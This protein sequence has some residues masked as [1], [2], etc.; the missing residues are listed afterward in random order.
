MKALFTALVL[1]ISTL[2]AFAETRFEFAR[3]TKAVTDQRFPVANFQV[4]AAIPCYAHESKVVQKMEQG[5][6][7]EVAVVYSYDFQPGRAYCQSLAMV[8][9][10]FAVSAEIFP[11]VRLIN[12]PGVTLEVEHR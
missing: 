12:A 3:I 9:F 1:A 8:K 5:N 4:T 10:P 7:L 11:Q 2:P 6:I